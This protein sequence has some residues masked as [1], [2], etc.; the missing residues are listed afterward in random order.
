MNI[1]IITQAKFHRLDL[2]VGKE[3]PF[4]L[5]ARDLLALRQTRLCQ[6][7]VIN[8]TP[9]ILRLIAVILWETHGRDDRISQSK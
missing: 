4:P 6:T 7:D 5:F 1:K 2:A 3:R 9:N 8:S